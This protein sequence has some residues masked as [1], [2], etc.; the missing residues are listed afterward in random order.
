MQVI[1]NRSF[2]AASLAMVA[3]IWTTLL[4]TAPWVADVTGE[5][6]GVLYAIG[7]LVCHQRPERSFHLGM[8]QL[9]VCARCL[10]VYAGVAMGLVAWTVAAM[11]RRVRWTR[12]AAIRALAASGLPTAITVA[13]AWLGVGDPS[14]AWRAALAVP[15]G[16]VGG[17]MLGAVSTDHLE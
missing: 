4:V 16:V 2:V 15:L 9:P 14:N 1:E 17:A 10:G 13:C 12:A 8:A 11:W 7:G 6:G 5:L 3:T